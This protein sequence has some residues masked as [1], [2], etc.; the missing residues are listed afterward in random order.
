MWVVRF[1]FTKGIAGSVVGPGV[2]DAILE[3]IVGSLVM[4]LSVCWIEYIPVFKS[5]QGDRSDSK[6]LFSRTEIWKIAS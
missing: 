5:P 1:V 6:S 4:R 3:A 2:A